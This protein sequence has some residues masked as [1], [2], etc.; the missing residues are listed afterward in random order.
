MAPEG[1]TS[2]GSVHPRRY[3]ASHRCRQSGLDPRPP[4]RDAGRAIPGRLGCTGEVDA[5]VAV[6]TRLRAQFSP[7]PDA[8]VGPAVESSSAPGPL[9]VRVDVAPRRL[10]RPA[11]RRRP[12]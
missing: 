6:D 8:L 12:K 11:A 4:G 7:G 1:P 9:R 10:G 2:D 3:R 5:W